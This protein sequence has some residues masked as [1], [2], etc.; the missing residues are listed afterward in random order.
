MNCDL[1]YVLGLAAALLPDM[2]KILTAQKDKL[3]IPYRL[4]TVT[5]DP[6]HPGTSFYEVQL[7]LLMLM[8]RICKLGLMTFHNIEAVLFGQTRDFGKS[9]AHGQFS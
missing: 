3:I 7:E 8:E 9:L 4:D 2:L 1:P 6:A 5:H